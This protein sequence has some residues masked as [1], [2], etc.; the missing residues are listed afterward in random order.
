MYFQEFTPIL[1]HRLVRNTQKRD[2]LRL[3][4][5]FLCLT[6]L[7]LCCLWLNASDKSF[8]KIFSDFF[9]FFSE[10]P[11]QSALKFS[12]I[13]KGKINFQNFPYGSFVFSEGCN[14]KYFNQFYQNTPSKRVIFLRNTK[15]LKKLLKNPPQYGSE[16]SLII[17]GLNF[18]NVFSARIPLF[19]QMG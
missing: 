17:E 9:I 7:K 18:L 19:V 14:E 4:S 16:I 10:I 3:V 15:R 2:Q 13:W 11:P 6:L 8:L 12:H 5:F 1:S